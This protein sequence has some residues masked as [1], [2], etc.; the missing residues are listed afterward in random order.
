MPNQDYDVHEW[1]GCAVTLIWFALAFA[2]VVAASKGVDW[3][4]VL[5]CHVRALNERKEY[6]MSPEERARVSELERDDLLWRGQVER[7]EEVIDAKCVS[8][9]AE[10]R[11]M[12]SRIDELEQALEHAWAACDNRV[13]A[14]CA[15][16]GKRFNCALYDF[17]ESRTPV[18]AAECKDGVKKKEALG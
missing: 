12:Q 16:C 15:W 8:S 4:K 5:G 6:T 7:R 9:T 13:L 14:G 1:R 2:L 3:S 18:A 17:H 11:A 10:R